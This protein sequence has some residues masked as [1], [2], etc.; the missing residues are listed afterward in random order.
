[1]SDLRKIMAPYT[2]IKQLKDEA[3]KTKNKMIDKLILQVI[4][5]T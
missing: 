1:M 4:E 2:G 3:N 5:F